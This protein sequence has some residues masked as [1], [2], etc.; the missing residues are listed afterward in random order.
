[1]LNNLK[2]LHTLFKAKNLNVKVSFSKFAMLR[3]KNCVLAGANGTHSVCVCQLHRNPKLMLDACDFNALQGSNRER[4]LS[5]YK[6]LLKVMICEN[7]TERCHLRSCSK[8]P[9]TNVLRN[10]LAKLF[11][12]NNIETVTYKQWTSTDR[13]SLETRIESVD[14]FLDC[15]V[16]SL[17]KLVKHSFVAKQQS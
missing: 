2:E 5:D 16:E 6:S 1:M 13:S 15:L 3:P 9:G 8:C 12:E 11:D 10:I 14:E 4:N 17:E 7:S